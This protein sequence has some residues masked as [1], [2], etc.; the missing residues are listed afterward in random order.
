M[1]KKLVLYYHTLRYLK[2]IQLRYQLYYRLR[3]LLPKKKYRQI[4]RS[5][6]TLKWANG[7]PSFKTYLGKNRFRFLNLEKEFD[8]IDWNYSGFGKLWTYN[9]N[10]FEFLN[11]INISKTD[12]LFLIQEYIKNEKHRKDGLEP[13]PISLRIIN[14]FKFL[15][16]NQISNRAINELLYQDACRLHDNLEYHLLANHLL[17]NGFALVF[18]GLYFNEDKILAVGMRIVSAELDEQVLEDGAHFEL[19]PMYH[20]IILYRVL[21]TCNL[22]KSNNKESKLL[23]FLEQKAAVMLGWLQQIS[24]NNNEIPLINDAAKHIAPSSAELLNYALQ[25]GITAHLKSI[26]SSGYRKYNWGEF[27]VLF[28]ASDILPKYQPGHAHADALQLLLR[29]KGKPILVDTGTSTYEKNAR[30]QLERSTSAHN[31]ITINGMDSSEVWGGFRVGKR[32]KVTIIEDGLDCVLASHDGYRKKYFRNLKWSDTFIV[33]KDYFENGLQKGVAHFHFHPNIKLFQDSNK[34]KANEVCFEFV[35]PGHIQISEY[36]YAEEF[37]KTCTAQKIT[38][39]FAGE[40]IVRIYPTE[41]TEKCCFEN[42]IPH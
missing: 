29:Y 36:Q 27:E 12:G 30:R 2:P 39:S 18:A 16:R 34:I 31:T 28:D 5:T 35:N 7:I 10:Y 15:S 19:S 8:T 42:F 40:N 22:L 24:W 23:R 1:F 38:F 37:N 41:P 32:A 25:L 4:P 20:Q 33:L 21:D 17:E 3:R 9:L 11:Q 26:D 14:W 6:A 13:Y